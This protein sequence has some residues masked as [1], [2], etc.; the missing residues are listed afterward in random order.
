M[1]AS[2]EGARYPAV[3]ESWPRIMM[4]VDMDAF[5][6]SIEQRDN[7]K[8]QGKP[9]VVGA[10]ADQRGVIAAASYEAR[11]FGLHSAMPSSQ[12]KQRCPKAIFM[13]VR[14]EHYQEVSKHLMNIL[15]RFSPLLEKLSV[16]E[17]FLDVTGSH[18]LFGGPRAMAQEIRQ[19][20]RRELDLTASLGVAPNKFLAK[21][22]SD[23]DKPNGCT[24]LPDDLSR[25]PEWLAPLP[26]SRIWGVGKKTEQQLV[27]K[28]IRTIRDVQQKLP[29]DLERLIGS[30]AADKLWRLAQGLDERP[31]VTVQKDK[32]ISSEMTFGKDCADPKLLD[33]VLLELSEKVGRRL[34]TTGYF[35]RT[36]FIKVRFADFETLS[37][38]LTLKPAS[39]HD[40]D[41][42][43]TAQA[44]FHKI[45]LKQSV[46]LLGVGVSQFSEEADAAP[47]N[48]LDLFAEAEGPDK[49]GALDQARYRF[50]NTR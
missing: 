10:Q 9:V 45:E 47:D 38:Q 2:G 49:D 42:I 23:Q 39:H 30:A 3:M 17:A 34:R 40:R 41:I 11:K 26:V 28:G 19:T 22:A 31:V 32:S 37:R 15:E 25:I 4:H 14:M 8:L 33:Q 48:Q 13:P 6:A 20:I 35:A 21:L 44:L 1:V 7:P 46:R 12:A 5:Y 36:V 29:S 24:F 18:H 27:A 43:C 16:D 50:V